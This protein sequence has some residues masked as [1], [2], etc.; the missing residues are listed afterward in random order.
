MN[1]YY[2]VT[3]SDEPLGTPDEKKSF[4]R[5]GYE[6]LDDAIENFLLDCRALDVGCVQL[7]EGKYEMGKLYL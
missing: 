2:V 7:W 4:R 3:K 5:V 6:N 1:E